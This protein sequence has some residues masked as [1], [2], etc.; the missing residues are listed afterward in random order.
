[1]IY[2]V[3]YDFIQKN[4]MLMACMLVACSTHEAARY[5]TMHTAGVYYV[6]AESGNDAA[7][8]TTAQTAWKSLSK[9]QTIQLV[10]GDT[11]KFKKGSSFTGPLFINQSGTEQQP[12]V[13][14]AYGTG[15]TAPSFTNPVFAQDNFG[16]CIRIKGSYVIVENLFF[17][18]T[19]AHKPGNYKTDGGWDVWEMGA[20]YLDKTAKYCIVRNN[21]IEDC[22][23]GIK[24]YGPYAIIENN[25]I[26]DCNRV[27]KQWGWGPIGIW[28]GADHQEARFNRI[29]NYRAEDPNIRWEGGTGGG[30]DG[31]A[32]EVDDARYD[33]SDIHIHHNYTKDCQ[34]F[35]EVTWTDVKQHPDYRDFRIHHNISDDYQQFTAIWQGAHFSI[36][37]NTIIRRKVNANDWGVFNITENNSKNKIR[38]NII[39]TEKDIPVFNTGLQ[40]THTPNNIISHNLYYAASGKLVMGKEGPGTAAVYGDPA[41]KE[42]IMARIPDHF[43]LK[44]NS[45][46]IDKAMNLGYTSDFKNARI[47]VGAMPDIGAF[48]KE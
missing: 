24:S 7:A 15:T 27:L 23:V 34:G 38:N 39:I 4:L 19:A 47:P 17:H 13:L 6:D 18:Q 48:E 32:F 44:E 2:H 28:L 31:G 29:V 20:V 12:I 21:E 9:L 46:A 16:N 8:G 3:L 43:D 37:H 35:L 5:E 41:L 1:M 22:V 10:P 36:D 14:T 11:I 40:G 25:D 33:K 42:Y 26:H 45:V 30:A